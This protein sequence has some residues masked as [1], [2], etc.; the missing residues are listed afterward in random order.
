MVAAAGLGDSWDL[1]VRY[2]I[3]DFGE[4]QS[5]P[6]PFDY[7]GPLNTGSIGGF[8]SDS[9]ENLLLFYLPLALVLGLAGSLLALGLR[10][11]RERWPQ[12]ASAVFAIG[13]AHY[14]ITRPDVFHTA[15]LAV[16]VAV[17]AAWA[18]TDW[19]ETEPRAARERSP[20]RVAAL[21]GAV[22]SAGALAYAIV[23]GLDRRWL[24]LRTD[25][26]ELRLPVADGVRVRTAER[27]AAGA[28][29][30]ARPRTRAGGPSDLR[31]HPPL[32][33]RQLRVPALL[34]PG[35]SPQ[36]DPL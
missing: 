10:F 33:S 32:G 2:P 26:A 15:P 8:L 17:L 9:A 11:R 25:Y 1:L 13:M 19:R 4:Y 12:V 36:S 18:I 20:L 6:F 27:A 16:M 35:R 23:E 30:P 7:D 3:E 5:L 24:E 34:R 28:R 14:L 31:R 29:G 21:A 22:L